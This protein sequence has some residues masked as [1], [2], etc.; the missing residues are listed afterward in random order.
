MRDRYREWFARY[1]YNY[2]NDDDLNNIL[3]D[4]RIIV[5]NG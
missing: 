5:S 3:L 4:M 2:K 1:T